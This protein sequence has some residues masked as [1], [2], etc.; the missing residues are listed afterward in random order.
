MRDII[1][2]FAIL[3]ALAVSI[4]PLGAFASPPFKSQARSSPGV[5]KYL[6]T[7]LFM[8]LSKPDGGEVSDAE[9][10]Q[11]LDSVVT[12][13]FPKGYTV[14]LAEGRFQDSSGRTIAEKSRVLV[15]LYPKSKKS[16]SRRKI[17]VI[18]AAYIKRFNQ[19][20]VVRM[21]LPG[22]VDVSFD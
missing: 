15:I 2:K 17:E 22:F 3:M 13:A 12:P 8:G 7:E 14:L 4:L 5:E 20:A 9:W 18:R 11:F 21:D 10:V 19:E 1:L 16:E 6:R